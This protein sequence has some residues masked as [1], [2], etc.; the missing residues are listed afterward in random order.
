MEVPAVLSGP[1]LT[2]TLTTGTCALVKN[3]TQGKDLSDLLEDSLT[4]IGPELSYTKVCAL[5]RVVFSAGNCFAN[6]KLQARMH[7]VQSSWFSATLALKVCILM[8]ACT[9]FAK[10]YT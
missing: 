1:S 8:P 7:A 9:S 4:C 10:C 5:T 2:V 3:S 6:P